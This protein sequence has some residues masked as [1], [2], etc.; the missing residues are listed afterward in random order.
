MEQKKAVICTYVGTN[1]WLFDPTAEPRALLEIEFKNTSE[2]MMMM[3]AT[4]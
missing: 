3:N 4:K 1:K 2:E